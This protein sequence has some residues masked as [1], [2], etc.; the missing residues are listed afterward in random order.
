MNGRRAA[1]TSWRSCASPS[2]R[3]SYRYNLP[4]VINLY[5]LAEFASRMIPL[6]DSETAR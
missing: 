3:V 1:A 6:R 4:H 5:T 2:R